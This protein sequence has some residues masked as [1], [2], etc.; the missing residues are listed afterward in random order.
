MCETRTLI[1]SKQPWPPWVRRF[2]T[3][4]F[5]FLL[6]RVS[7]V[8]I[9]MPS[10]VN[11]VTRIRLYQIVFNIAIRN[12]TSIS[13]LL[14]RKSTCIE[15]VETRREGRFER[16]KKVDLAFRHIQSTL[17]AQLLILTQTGSGFCHD[18]FGVVRVC[19]RP[20][21]RLRPSRAR[22]RF[23]PFSLID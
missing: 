5:F 7:R 16:A 17:N 3:F 18:A 6:T 22:S 13:N 14:G 15:Y 21:N 20:S 23:S 2:P 10:I 1:L 9:E 12:K 19:Q 4:F 8:P 11:V